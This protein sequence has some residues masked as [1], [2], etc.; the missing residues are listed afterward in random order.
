MKMNLKISKIIALCFAPMLLVAATAPFI[1]TSCESKK[2]TSTTDNGQIPP[3]DNGQIPP[4][5]NGQTPPDDNGQTPPDDNG[6]T[7]T[8]TS[9]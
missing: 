2:D 7:P 8:I 6:Q 3:D 9:V 4:D 5:D 1:L